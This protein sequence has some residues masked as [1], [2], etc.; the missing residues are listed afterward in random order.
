MSLKAKFAALVIGIV[1]CFSMPTALAAD[2]MSDGAMY[3]AS[4]IWNGRIYAAINGAAS[5]L[6]MRFNSANGNTSIINN[7]SPRLQTAAIGLELGYAFDKNYVAPIRLAFDILW[8]PNKIFKIT[9]LTTGSANYGH[10]RIASLVFLGNVFYDFH[11]TTEFVPY[12]GAGLGMARHSTEL[13]VRNIATDARVLTSNNKTTTR[14]A[15]DAIA[16]V[17]MHLSG[18]FDMDVF[19]RLSNL[20]T[21]NFGTD[22]TFVS[23]AI[24][25]VANRMYAIDLGL[26]LRY[27]IP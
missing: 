18:N 13:D 1:C 6:Y 16:G 15:W 22:A 26:A 19:G 24:A 20:G 9:P 27:N 23:P 3:Q 11:N 4:S 25:A 7:A 17:A 14:L 2:E 8:R 10:G 21:A 12:V 5:W